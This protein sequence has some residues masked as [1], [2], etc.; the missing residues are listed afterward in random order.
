MMARLESFGATDAS[1]RANM[2]IPAPK[3]KY[4]NKCDK[5]CEYE[6]FFKSGSTDD[7][8]ERVCKDC[9]NAYRR[10]NRAERK[11]RGTK[12]QIDQSLE[13]LVH[14]IQSGKFEVDQKWLLTEL[15]T[16]YK[17][18]MTK[19]KLRCLEMI[20]EV[21]GY[22]NRNTDERSLMDSLLESLENGTEENPPGIP[23]S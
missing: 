12:K 10:Q 7:G 6:Q 3:G 22:N 1:E 5:W 15:L 13:S 16:I 4:C 23:G 21:S 8:Y 11:A 20:K 2:E 19:D 9:R 18:D 14:Q 17:T